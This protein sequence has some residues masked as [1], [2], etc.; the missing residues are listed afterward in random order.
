MCCR[1]GAKERDNGTNDSDKTSK[2]STAPVPSIIKLSEDLTCL[3]ARGEA[4]KYNHDGQ[5]G[6]DVEKQNRAFDQM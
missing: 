6:S 2:P 4:P 3:G 1:V 5:E